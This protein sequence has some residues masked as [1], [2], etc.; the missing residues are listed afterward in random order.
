[1]KL[2]EVLE[3]V[4]KVKPN[5][6]DDD[7]LTGFVNLLEQHAYETLKVPLEERKVLKWGVDGNKPLVIPP[8][9][10]VAYLSWLKAQIDYNDEEH[11]SYANNQAQFNADYTEFEAYVVREGLAKR[12]KI[13]IR[14]YN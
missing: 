2:S 13:Y 8:P 6:Y 9:H 14:N 7:T 11:A 12:G 3:E 10:D 5:G 1:M 4:K